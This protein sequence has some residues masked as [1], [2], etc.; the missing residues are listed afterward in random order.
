MSRVRAVSAALLLAVAACASE[1]YRR[2]AVLSTPPA[3]APARIEIV[4][5]AYLQLPAGYGRTLPQGSVWE[6]RGALPEGAVYR[7][8]GGIFT[9][10]GAQV[11]EAYLVI[12]ANQLVGFYLPVEKAY[13]PYSPVALNI[14]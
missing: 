12:A 9:V 14:K 1:V 5:E 13:A 11:H 10:E 3:T 6:L 7:R 2:D 4:K 8:V